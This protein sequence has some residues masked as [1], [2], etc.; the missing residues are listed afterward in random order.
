M[1]RI[2]TSTKAE[3]LFGAGKHGWKNGNVGLGIVPTDFNA[4]WFNGVQE[5][6]LKIIEGAG[7][8]PDAVILSQVYQSIKRLTGANVTTVNFANTPFVLTADHAGLVIMDATAGNISATLPAANV[9]AN[10][11]A[12]FRFVRSD[13]TVNTATV[14]SAGADTFLDVTTSFTLSGRGDF[15]G[16]S[17]DAASKWLP[18]SPSAPGANKAVNPEFVVNQDE[19]VSPY[20]AASAVYGHDGWRAGAGGVTYSFATASGLTT[21]TIT[22]GTLLHSVE[23]AQVDSATVTISWT[24]TAQARVG[25]GAYAASPVTV[26][27]LALNTQY[28]VEFSAGTLT[29][30]KIENGAQATSYVKRAPMEELEKAV[31]YYNRTPP[32]GGGHDFGI[33]TNLGALSANAFRIT[34]PYVYPMRQTPTVTILTQT[35]V[36]RAGSNLAANSGTNRFAMTLQGDVAAGSGSAQWQGVRWKLDCRLT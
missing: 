10:T 29:K 4:E 3:N 13:A 7:L 17:A 8:V 1:D 32:S 11:P 31:W 30:L 12:S 34:I 26:T 36:D 15:K 6:L 22:A 27:G 28:N 21:A 24:G 23:A 14:N 16:L 18:V 35:Q 9:L 33:P 20:T 19:V 25:G 5:E 2:N